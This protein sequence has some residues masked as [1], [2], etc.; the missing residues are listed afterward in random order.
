MI[1]CANR[2]IMKIIFDNLIFYRQNRKIVSRLYFRKRNAP[3]NRVIPFYKM[4]TV[5]H[6]VTI[7][8]MKEVK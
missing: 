1:A 7:S 8:K 4:D 5:L 3:N 2:C 6:L